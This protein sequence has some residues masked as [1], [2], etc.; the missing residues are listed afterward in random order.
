MK[1]LTGEHFMELDDSCSP[2]CQAAVPPRLRKI[3]DN[4]VK[5]GFRPGGFIQAVLKN[6]LF[7]AVARADPVS[8]NHLKEV[9]QYIFNAAPSSTH[10]S[11]EKVEAHLKKAEAWRSLQQRMR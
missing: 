5:F 11:H 10:G 1:D 8:M 6:N 9:V 4:Y 2:A 7:S 3:I